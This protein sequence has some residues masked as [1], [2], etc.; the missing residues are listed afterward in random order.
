MIMFKSLKHSLMAAAAIGSLAL[1]GAIAPALADTGHTVSGTTPLSV[2]QTVSASCLVNANTTVAFP[3]TGVIAAAT[4]A[5]GG[6]VVV[7]CT[8]T[9]PYNIGLDAGASAG[10]S[11]TNRAMTATGGGGATIK[12]GLYQDAGYTTNWGNTD[13][14][15]TLAET[16]TGDNQTFPVYGQEPAQTT[17]APGNYA[18]SV[19]VTVYY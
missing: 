6:T 4:N 19:N 13:G 5:S 17:P 15:D 18:D 8:N 16:G 10:A 2:T 11:T 12:Y 3:T 1:G 14:T 9:T 7:Q